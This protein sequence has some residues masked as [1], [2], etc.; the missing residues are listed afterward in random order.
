[1]IGIEEGLGRRCKIKVFDSE[2]GKESLSINA[3]ASEACCLL[4]SQA[5]DKLVSGFNDNTIRIFDAVDGKELCTLVGH[6][7][8]V[9]SLSLSGSKLVSCSDDKTIRVWDD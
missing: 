5:D 9:N 2:S 3:N 7:K 1:V 4:F 8:S 6:A